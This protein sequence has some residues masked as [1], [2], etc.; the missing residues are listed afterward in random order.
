VERDEDLIDTIPIIPRERRGQLYRY[1]EIKINEQ[2]QITYEPVSPVSGGIL[3]LQEDGCE[4]VIEE[5]WCCGEKSERSWLTSDFHRGC[6]LEGEVS[7]DLPLRIK[8]LNL[9]PE[10]AKIWSTLTF[11][12]EEKNEHPRR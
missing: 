2:K 10:T 1:L 6:L 8:L 5:I 3:Y 11:S 12:K 9:G 7:R 4:V